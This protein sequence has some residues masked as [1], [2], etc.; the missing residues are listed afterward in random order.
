MCVICFAA[1]DV[2]NSCGS[3]FAVAVSFGFAVLWILELWLRFRLLRGCGIHSGFSVFG[4][5]TNEF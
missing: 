2:L 4:D 5:F 1:M 3:F